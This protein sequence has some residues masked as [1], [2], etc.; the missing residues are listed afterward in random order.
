M[1]LFVSRLKMELTKLRLKDRICYSMG[2][3]YS[4]VNL[5]LRLQDKLIFLR[6]WIDFNSWNIKRSRVQS[7]ASK[8]CIHS[9]NS[10]K[11]NLLDCW[12]IISCQ[13]FKW[14][15][16]AMEETY[17]IIRIINSKG[18]IIWEEGLILRLDLRTINSRIILM[19]IKLKHI[20]LINS[21]SKF[22]HLIYNKWYSSNSNK[23]SNRCLCNNHLTSIFNLCQCLCPC[24][25][26]KCL[27]LSIS[28]KNN[29][30]NKYSSNKIWINFL[31]NPKLILIPINITK[32]LQLHFLLHFPIHTSIK[33]LFLN[34]VFL[35]NHLIWK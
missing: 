6:K 15:N 35:F 11:L 5:K 12:W 16:K 10:F 3:S 18:L 13:L 23:L 8:D 20:K 33:W 26:N 7:Q 14:L 25:C 9:Y 21:R 31:L 32:E 17:L 24:Q 2:I 1:D 28:N 34:K 4:S 22:N 29:L 30:F 19:L 27:I